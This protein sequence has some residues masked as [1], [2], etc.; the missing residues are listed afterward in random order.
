MYPK[1][2]TTYVLGDYQL[3]IKDISV[4]GFWSINIDTHKGFLQENE[5]QFCCTSNVIAESY[6]DEFLPSILAHTK[7]L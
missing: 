5:D 2:Q 6:K 4:K 1:N 3:P 7:T